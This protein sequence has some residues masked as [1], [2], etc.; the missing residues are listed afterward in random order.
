MTTVAVVCISMLF[1]L[2][3]ALGAF[4]LMQKKRGSS[5]NSSVPSGGP[6]KPFNVGSTG[7]TFVLTWY[8]FQDNTPTNSTSTA[9]G[10]PMKPYVHCAVPFRLLKKFGGPLDYGDKLFVQFLKGRKMPNGTQHTGWLEL[11]DFCGDSGDDSYCYQNVKGKKYPNIDIFI[12]DI[13]KSGMDTKHK[14]CPGPAGNGQE[15]TKVFTGSPS[16]WVSDY[17]GAASGTGKCGDAASAR[18][19][20]GTCYFYQAPA[21]T[22]KWCKS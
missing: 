15:I 17:G 3:I 22:K 20:H 16:S 1:T 8:S 2:T 12:G 4:A 18:K 9:S 11:Q 10:R 5:S 14:D 13:T 7:N 6:M 21:S 19:D